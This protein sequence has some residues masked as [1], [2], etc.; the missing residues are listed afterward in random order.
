M[1]EELWSRISYEGN[2]LE[3]LAG[4]KVTGISGYPD[5]GTC[6]LIVDHSSIVTFA[7]EGDCCSHSYYTDVKQF[8]ELVGATIS[9]VEERH[10]DQIK[11]RQAEAAGAESVR[12]H[13]L[14]F[15]TDKGHVTID[16]RND[17]NGYYDGNIKACIYPLYQ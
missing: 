11:E 7:L 1:V 17:S 13:F 5:D 3:E 14:V 8:N 4:K 15:T 9:K 16:W 2:I 12:W 10:G 6:S